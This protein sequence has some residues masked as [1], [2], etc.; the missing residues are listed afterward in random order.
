MIPFTAT[1]DQTR[2]DLFAAGL[3]RM[4]TR[5][6]A[7]AQVHYE[8]QAEKWPNE[9]QITRRDLVRAETVRRDNEQRG[10]AA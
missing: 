6:F 4:D 10:Q 5:E 1:N 2:Y 3:R 7:W 8:H 9:E